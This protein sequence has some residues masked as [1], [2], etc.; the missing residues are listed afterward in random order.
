MSF[1]ELK[2]NG[3]PKSIASAENQDSSS[4][5]AYLLDCN[6]KKK[7]IKSI[8][9]TTKLTSVA[10][11]D[12]LAGEQN[13]VKYNPVSKNNKYKK[14]LPK[15][16]QF[17]PCYNIERQNLLR[18]KSSSKNNGKSNT[19]LTTTFSCSTAKCNSIKDDTNIRENKNNKDSNI[20]MSASNLDSPTAGSNL[21]VCKTNAMFSKNNCDSDSPIST[22][23][24]KRDS[25][26][27]KLQNNEHL[28]Q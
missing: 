23:S 24:P 22:S 1:K 11:F 20:S 19:S 5:R 8:T 10:D 26:F 18:H 12:F 25:N 7:K 27:D 15:L 3:K 28:F 13:L 14:N 2:I 17:V 21:S 6:N 4:G 16:S 9:K